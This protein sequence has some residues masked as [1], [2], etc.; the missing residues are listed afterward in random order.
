MISREVQKVPMGGIQQQV[1]LQKILRDHFQDIRDISMREADLTD[2]INVTDPPY[3]ATGN[4]VTDDTAAINLAIAAA[5]ADRLAVYFPS[6]DYLITDA[7]TVGVYGLWYGDGRTTSVIKLSG[8]DAKVNL[9]DSVTLRDMRINGDDTANQIGIDCDGDS[10]WRLDNV[11]VD[12]CD[13]GISL[14]QSWGGLLISCILKD[15][16][17][18]GVV[19][20]AD[21][22]IKAITFIGGEIEGNDVAFL[23]AGHSI[24]CKFL[25]TV[26]Q[27]NTSYGIRSAHAG[28]IAFDLFELDS[29][30]FEANGTGGEL[31]IEHGVRGL[32]VH[33]C[34]I[35]MEDTNGK[36]IDLG[37]D[38]TQVVLQTNKYTGGDSDDVAV[39]L[40]VDVVNAKLDNNIYLTTN[41]VHVTDNSATGYID[42]NDDN[43]GI[44]KSSGD[45]IAKN[46]VTSEA[47]N[48][49]VNNGQVVCNE[50]YVVTN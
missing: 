42:I 22:S 46:N 9:N 23:I 3:N 36:C 15:N 10:K 30:H 4:G 34:I 17:S 14:G 45:V 43:S 8:V 38:C 21:G 2:V 13:S 24:V 12:H 7:I 26:I 33:N 32:N 11:R 16:V 50:G 27:G 49:V 20:P 44:I 35:D 41:S 28:G 31:S 25:G 29:C 18:N 47:Y 39:I 40:G 19:V 6:G 37:G 5:A 48:I 1:F